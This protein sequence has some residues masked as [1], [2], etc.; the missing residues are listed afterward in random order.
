MGNGGRRG[1]RYLFLD[2]LT[3]IIALETELTYPVRD[4]DLVLLAC[5]ADK[6]LPPGDPRRHDF[7]KLRGGDSLTEIGGVLTSRIDPGAFHHRLLCGHRGCGK[8]TELRALKAWADG[9]GFFTIWIEV[10]LFFGLIEL[11]FSDLYLLAAQSVA[12]EMH[13]AGTPLPEDRLKRVVE[14]FA[15]VT[16][17]DLE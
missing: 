5:D 16:Q 4:I 6:S 12:R 11:Q 7:S 2:P 15:K 8:S 17:E 9:A 3:R 13:D 1:C 10:D 14:W